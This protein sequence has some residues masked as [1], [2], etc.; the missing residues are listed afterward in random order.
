M[1]TQYFC[2]CVSNCSA[3]NSAQCTCTKFFYSFSSTSSYTKFYRNRAVNG[4]ARN[5]AG[6]MCMDFSAAF[7][8][9]NSAETTS[10]RFSVAFHA[11]NCST[12]FP[13]HFLH[14]TLQ[15]ARARIVSAACREI[16]LIYFLHIFLHAFL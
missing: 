1:C 13:A 5:S 6:I 2:S 16:F 9:Q 7:R 11:Q 15:S 10:T 8:A 12:A 3:Q 14:K 4:S